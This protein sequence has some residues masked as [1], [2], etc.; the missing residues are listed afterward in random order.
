V[1]EDWQQRQ[2][3][4]MQ[5]WMSGKGLDTHDVEMNS[6]KIAPVLAL[7]APS[8]TGT[9]GP[10]AATALSYLSEEV[11]RLLKDRSG[12]DHSHAEAC[13][14]QQDP[15]LPTT[16]PWRPR[17]DCRGSGH[18]LP[19]V[20]AVGEGT[21]AEDKPDLQNLSSMP[22]QHHTAVGGGEA[23]GREHRCMGRGTG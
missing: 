18:L 22:R 7:R 20:Q 17:L 10:T 23:P 5:T 15:C 2:K 21:G 12:A 13:Y 1:P 16:E 3:L 9:P 14:N 11:P 4:R 8:P 19:R 6:N